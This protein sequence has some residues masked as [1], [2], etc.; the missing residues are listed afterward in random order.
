MRQPEGGLASVGP[1]RMGASDQRGPTA[2]TDRSRS[3]QADRARGQRRVSEASILNDENY[4]RAMASV[5]ATLSRLQRCS[6]DEKERLKS[7]LQSMQTMLRKLTSGRVEIV[8]FGEIS[9]GKSA[10]INALVGR[11]VA[12]VDVQGGWTKEVWNVAWE[13]NGWRVPG[14]AQSEIVLVD[15]PGTERG[16]RA[17][18]G[19][20]GARRRRT[21]GP[22]SVRYRL[23]PHGD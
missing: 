23:G 9:T 21:G 2:K 7:E 18:T 8:V 19:Q 13:A 16:R 17:G 15:T 14:L 11:P 4:Q 22:D 1:A 10:L 20:H 3:Y 6:P 12:A 5:E